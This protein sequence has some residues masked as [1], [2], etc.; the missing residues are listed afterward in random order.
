MLKCCGCQTNFILPLGGSFLSKNFT[1]PQFNWGFSILLI[2]DT[3][4]IGDHRSRQDIFADFDIIISRC[5]PY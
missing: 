3:L 5:F 1:D 2:I 4:R